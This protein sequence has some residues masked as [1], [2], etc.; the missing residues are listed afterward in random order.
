MAASVTSVTAAKVIQ[1][2]PFLV[3][4]LVVA[5]ANGTDAVELA[6]GGPT[7]TQPDMIYITGYHADGVDGGASNVAWD[8]AAPSDLDKISLFGEYDTGTFNYKVYCTFFNQARQDG[9]SI[10]SD[11]NT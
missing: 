9:Q 11:N 6:H 1:S 3:T 8:S 4:E 7:D 5:T 2:T 10:T